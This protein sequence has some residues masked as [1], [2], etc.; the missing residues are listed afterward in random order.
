MDPKVV[1]GIYGSA[2]IGP[3]C[4]FAAYCCWQYKKDK[5]IRHHLL[6]KK[7]IIQMEKKLLIQNLSKLFVRD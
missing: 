7:R 5:K 3:I 1:F 4:L 2:L 6:S